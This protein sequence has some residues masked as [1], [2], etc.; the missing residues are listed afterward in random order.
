MKSKIL[1]DLVEGEN[2]LS[3]KTKKITR[4]LSKLA[5]ITLIGIGAYNVQ[6]WVFKNIDV[7]L[8]YISAEL[9]LE[10]NDLR[11]ELARYDIYSEDKADFNTSQS[12]LERLKSIDDLMEYKAEQDLGY[13]RFVP[14]TYEDVTPQDSDIFY[15][16]VDDKTISYLSIDDHL[17]KEDVII[18]DHIVIRG[19]D[20][21]ILA[22]SYAPKNNK[23]DFYIMTYEKEDGKF[24]EKDRI[25]TG[26]TMILFSSPDQVLFKNYS[27][28]TIDAELL[29]PRYYNILDREDFLDDFTRMIEYDR[30]IHYQVIK[31]YK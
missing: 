7:P 27:I 21:E 4:K 26:E 6:S 17:F 12:N 14:E 20:S 22:V 23:N 2:S 30:E 3:R 25:K 13:E 15:S 31:T 29:E 8:A 10:K 11:T 16:R 9:D 5:L 18:N 1:S 24:K 19:Q 28:H